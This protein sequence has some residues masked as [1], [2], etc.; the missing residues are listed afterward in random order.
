MRGTMMDFPLTLVP[1]FERAGKLFGAVEI[2]SRRPDRLIARCTYGDVYRR[3]RRLARALEL[4]GIGRGD[5]V[6]T[7]MWNHAAHLEC[8]FGIP[9]AGGV[10]HTLNLRLHPNELAYTVTHAG[11]RFLIV[12]DVLLPVYESFRAR[13]HFERVFVAPFGGTA[14]PREHEHYEDFLAAADDDFQYPELEENEAA[15][16]CFTSGTTGKPKGVVYS[17][18]ALVLHSLAECI[19]G[20]FGISHGDVILACSSMFHANAWGVPY[21]AAMMGAKL[22]LPGPHLD[23]ESLLDLIE[24][25]CVTLAAGVPV[26]WFS[27]LQLLENNPGRWKFKRPLRIVSGGSAVPEALFR[28]LDRF[29]IHARQ[30][31]GMTETAPM[32]SMGT[33]KSTLAGCTEEEE[34]KIRTKQGM[35]APFVEMRV[36]TSEG[37]APWDD[38]TFGELEV[39]GPWVAASYLDAPETGDRWSNDGWFRTGDVATIDAEGYIRIVDRSKDMIKSGGEWISSVDLENALMCHPGV[40][41]AAVI[42]IPHPKWQERPLAVVV[43]K[44]GAQVQAEDLRAFLADKFAKWQLPDAFI[45][46]SEIPRTSVGKFLKSK[47]RE[48]YANWEWK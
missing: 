31:W 34:Y 4:A 12:D 24:Q 1:I 11:D 25:E 9:V 40:S 42:G 44:K 21:T 41:E 3:A 5:R 32:A 28:G 33:I 17:H 13:V 7:L 46:A 18:R 30:I 10:M 48:E 8:Y 36:M 39:R 2:V 16:V 29:G 15:T 37:E 20:T 27:V 38:K 19:D 47:L 43:A 45:F 23:A 14:I 6:A 26:L 22:I 35:P